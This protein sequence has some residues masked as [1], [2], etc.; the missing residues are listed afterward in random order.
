MGLW[1]LGLGS[2]A[3]HCGFREIVLRDLD[4]WFKGFSGLG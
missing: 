2:G 1:D 3:E 4:N